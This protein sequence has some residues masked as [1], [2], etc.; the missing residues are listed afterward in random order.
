MVVRGETL[1]CAQS[2]G[3][4]FVILE[5]SLRRISAVRLLGVRLFAAL[6]VTKKIKK[7]KEKD[8]ILRSLRSLENDRIW[9]VLR[10]AQNDKKKTKEK[11][12]ILHFVQKDG[13]DK[14]KRRDSSV[15]ALPRE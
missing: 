10:C 1:R 4:V 6:R 2:D 8:E 3:M 11:D 14:G 7:T 12:E 5:L 13:K 9:E 15:A